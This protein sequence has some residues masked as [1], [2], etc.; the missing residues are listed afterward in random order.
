MSSSVQ[1]KSKK[2]MPGVSGLLDIM[3]PTVLKFQ[4]KEVISGELY[5]RT[6]A[7]VSY[8]PSV[9]VAWLSRV[10]TLPGVVMSMHVAPTDPHS[11]IDEIR[12]T[13]GEL[14]GKLANSNNNVEKSRAETQLKHAEEL[15][16]KM[17]NESQSVFY[18]TVVL[19]VSANDLDTLEQRTKD[20]LSKLAGMG[21]R[22][23]V[24]MIKQEEG[25]QSVAPFRKLDQQ[26]SDMGARNMPAMTVAAAYPF[27][28]S[29]L[30]DGRGVLFG[31]DKSSGLV[32]VDFWKRE[33]S[34][35]NSNMLVLGKPGTGKS[36][37]VKKILMRE[38]A[39]DTTII[40]IDPEREYRDLCRN[41][42]GDWIDCGGGSRGRINPL[43]ARDVPLDD[44]EDE[45]ETESLFSEE[46]LNARGPLA[47][48][49]QTLRVFF[50]AYAKEITRTDMSYLEVALEE[51]YQEKGITWQSDIL[52]IKNDEWPVLENLYYKLDEKH[53]KDPQNSVWEKLKM[54]LRPMAIGADSAIWNGHTTIQANSGFVVLDTHNLVE[55]DEAIQRAQY[56]NV[57]GWSW[58]KISQDRINKVLL[59]GD[60]YYI[61]V[62]PDNP[63]VLKFSRNTSKRI[64][65]YE[66][67]LMVIT[68][69]MIDFDDPSVRRYGQALIDNP[70]YKLIM[71]QGDRDIESLKKLMNL[72]ERETQ[73]LIDGKRGEALFIAGNRR[74]HMDVEVSPFE[75]EMFGRGGGR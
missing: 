19:M 56:F 75:L 32:L 4:P 41:L 73:A 27:V 43:Q 46:T 28:F 12:V 70:T 8:R 40:V 69:S 30:N 1:K 2:S 34:R 45:D 66:G 22:G 18:V 71:G 17:D 15:L 35:T 65:K 63:Q 68:H 26:V 24:L 62:D 61:N 53:S 16:K 38:Y 36:T 57:L 42:G 23:R 29:G 47:I 51:V 14:S 5:Q 59:A 50:Q 52:Q 74:I 49:F 60:E 39:D 67:S 58:N 33:G 48:H 3:S 6:L 72:S 10:A 44:D 11:L 13:M 7:I 25:Y 64:R 9:Q 37:A 55:G 31:K 21:M 54:I 20:V